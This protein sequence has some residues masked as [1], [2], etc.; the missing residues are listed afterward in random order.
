MMSGFSGSVSPL[1]RSFL[2]KSSFAPSCLAF[3]WAMLSAASEISTAR[4]SAF[5]SSSASV[6]AMQPEPVRNEHV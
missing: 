2:R 5:G 6:I 4:T 3:F 1:R